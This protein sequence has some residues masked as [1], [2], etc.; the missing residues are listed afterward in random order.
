MILAYLLILAELVIVSW[1]DIKIK[2]ISNF[3]FVIN[4][5]LAVLFHVW[6][7][8]VYEFDWT[9]FIMPIS[10]VFVGFFLF[11]SKIMGAG[12]S[13]YLASLFIAVPVQ[14][15]LGLFENLVYST[16]VVGL[17]TILISLI[18][19]FKKIKAYAFS[20]YWQGLKEFIGTRF[21]YGPV[22]LLAWLM[23]GFKI[24]K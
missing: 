2:K 3:W 13:K 16:I 21:S 22:I 9:L 11:L 24:W 15:H 1:I 20:N 23:L 8:E 6:L 5:V 18:R 12:D 7:S 10:W 19:D 17:M 14:Y 4:I